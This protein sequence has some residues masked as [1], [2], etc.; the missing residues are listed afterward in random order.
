M[1][2][3]SVVSAE[4]TDG[5][6]LLAAGADGLKVVDI[7]D[8]TQ[9]VIVAS[10]NDIPDVRDIALMGD[11]LF[12]AAGK[13]GLVVFD[14]HDLLNITPV[15][16]YPVADCAQRVVA[17]NGKAAVVDTFGGLSVFR[18]VEMQ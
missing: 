15:A 9:P 14:L 11:S 17:G 1:L 4:G 18:F 6:L 8:P 2:E 5:Y 7:A 3:E 10:R 12:V 13:A 16:V